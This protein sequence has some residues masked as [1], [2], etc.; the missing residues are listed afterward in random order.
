MLDKPI[1]AR[2][3]W[4]AGGLVLHALILLA[5]LVVLAKTSRLTSDLAMFSFLLLASFFCA[6]DLTTLWCGPSQRRGAVCSADDPLSGRLAQAT[7]VA[8]LA[9]FWLAM[10]ERAM[11]PSAASTVSAAGAC[12]GAALMLAGG[13]LRRS[14]I[15]ALGPGFRTDFT[16]TRPLVRSGVFRFVRHPSESGLLSVALGACLLLSSGAALLLLATVLLPLSLWR[17]RL[18]ERRLLDAFGDDYLRYRRQVSGL[19]PLTYCG[20]GQRR[21]SGTGLFFGEDPPV[22]SMSPPPKNVPVPLSSS[23]CELRRRRQS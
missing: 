13:L 21:K 14:A 5:P 18:E 6:C 19:L 4:L 3:A 11:S 1:T 16:P 22:A 20:F 7:G 23:A 2:P 8:L 9:L 15:V 10:I 17:I 12:A